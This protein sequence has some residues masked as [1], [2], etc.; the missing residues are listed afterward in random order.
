MSRKGVHYKGMILHFEYIS[1]VKVYVGEIV[2]CPNVIS[3]SA[4]N[5]LELKMIMEET[6]DNYVKHRKKLFS[7]DV[8]MN[9]LAV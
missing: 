3:F 4:K 5:L 1:S 6:V 7:A 2:N 9:L 8:V